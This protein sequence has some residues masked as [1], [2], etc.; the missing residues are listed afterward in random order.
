MKGA[1]LALPAGAAALFFLFRGKASA[2]TPKAPAPPVIVPSPQGAGTVAER[3]ARVIATGNPAA[4]RFEAGR[5]RQEGYTAQ[6]AELERVAAT[7]EAGQVKPPAPAM[8]G[9][10]SPAPVK[11][12]MPAPLPPVVIVTPPIAPVP[13]PQAP[14]PTTIA[15]PNLKRGS[16]GARVLLVQ[17]RLAS[18]G[19]SLGKSGADGQFGPSTEAAVKAFQKSNGLGV[20]GIVGPATQVALAGTGAKGPAPAAVKPPAVV[21]PAPVVV[22]PT[23]V[24]PAGPPPSSAP[25]GRAP[26]ITPA[27]R[28]LPALLRNGSSTGYKAPAS[29]GQAVKDWQQVLRELG[30]TTA[31]PD[32]KFGPGTEAATRAFQSAA[33]SAAAKA[34]P[35]KKP[36]TV[37]GVVGPATVARAAEARVVTTGPAVFTGDWFGYDPGPMRAPSTMQPDSPLP[38]VIPMMAPT[39][40]DPERA[41]AARLTHMLVTAPRGAEDRTLVALFQTRNGLRPTGFYGPSVA[42]TLAQRFGI[43]PPTPLYWTESRTGKAKSNYRDA[44]RMLA[45]RDPQRSEEWLRAG[46]V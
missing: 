41:L 1:A 19:Y 20:D 16:S 35:P 26:T 18:L 40:P 37:D 9:V 33:N 6:A 27:L 21:A 22:R 3:M 45:E 5:L 23:P 43:V 11:P 8:P 30:F 31:A 34:T 32:G 17:H 15:G 36:L 39:P 42:L 14:A 12:P 28:A 13:V 38:G 10:P 46:G 4:I 2:A 24:L 44:L 25:A 29:S 7:I